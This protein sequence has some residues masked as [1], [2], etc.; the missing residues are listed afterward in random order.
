MA[1]LTAFPVQTHSGVSAHPTKGEVTVAS[2]PAEKQKDI[3]QKLRLYGV[4]QAFANG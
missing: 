3:D 2:N 1:S 4:I